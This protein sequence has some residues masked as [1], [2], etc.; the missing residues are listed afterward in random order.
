[1]TISPLGVV[2]R[3]E[4]PGENSGNNDGNNDDDG[5]NDGNNDFFSSSSSSN[6]PMSYLT[7][8]ESSLTSG[9]CF[10][11]STCLIFGRE[12]SFFMR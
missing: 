8:S 3:N 7:C 11:F 12:N 1:M 9:A 4:T 2:S 6:H 10:L 5:N